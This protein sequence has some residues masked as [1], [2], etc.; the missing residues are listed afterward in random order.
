MSMVVVAYWKVCVLCLVHRTQKVMNKEER[1]G[2]RNS[3]WTANVGMLLILVGSLYVLGPFVFHESV[4]QNVSPTP[5]STNLFCAFCFRTWFVAFL[6][7]KRENDRLNIISIHSRLAL[8]RS[9]HDIDRTLITLVGIA[10]TQFCFKTVKQLQ[11]ES[12][13]H[14]SMWRS[15]NATQQQLLVGRLPLA[16]FHPFGHKQFFVILNKG[17]FLVSPMVW[18]YS[19]ILFLW[20]YVVSAWCVPGNDFLRGHRVLC[21][22]SHLVHSC[23]GFPSVFGEDHVGRCLGKNVLVFQNKFYRNYSFLQFTGWLK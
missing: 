8:W 13:S 2:E 9:N 6:P 23:L 15:C 11:A 4:S 7:I 22:R 10:A 21:W 3:M 5:D 16:W 12:S 18:W 14:V 17:L 1:E 20:G 19:Q